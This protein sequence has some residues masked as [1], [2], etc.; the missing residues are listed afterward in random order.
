MLLLIF[1][2]VSYYAVYF[3]TQQTSLAKILHPAC[4]IL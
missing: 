1:I 4:P 3:S 2:T